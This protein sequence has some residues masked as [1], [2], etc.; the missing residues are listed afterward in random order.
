MALSFVSPSGEVSIQDDLWYVA[1]SSN[2]GQTDFKYVFDVFYK[3]QQLIRTKVFPEPITGK[4]Y[5][6]ATQ[7]VRNEITYD[8]FKP[9]Q[10]DNICISQPSTSGQIGLTYQV[11]VGEDY[12][13]LTT[14][15]LASGST[16][17]YNYL[18]PLFNRR[19]LK[20]D[21]WNNRFLSNRP[22]TTLRHNITDRILIGVKSLVNGRYF[23]VRAYGNSNNFIWQESYLYYQI[24]TGNPF[25]QLDVG[26]TNINNVLF[27]YQITN[28][29]KYW[30]VGFQ[31]TIT[32]FVRVY[33]EC[34]GKYKPVLLHFIN[35]FGM[36]DTARFNLVSKLSMDL[37]RKTYAKRDY[38]F[39]GNSVDY[40]DANNVYK[41]SSINY[42][43][44]IDWKYHLTMNYPTDAEYQ[45]LSE[46]IYSPQI[47]AEIDGAFYP[48]SIINTN[49]E[50]SKNINNGLRALEIDIAMNQTRYGYRR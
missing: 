40:Y 28:D 48:V 37:E 3:G 9:L 34:D 47:Y 5:F 13:G 17:A 24:P 1:S 50:Y 23:N 31:D 19:K 30:E 26:G 25:L 45:W 18:P 29:V 4:G 35:A 16:T 44:K 22:L 6:N 38:S 7:V 11:S 20:L 15:N 46:L 43:S 49:Y 41:E 21:N 12:A 10:G 36:F 14:L 33:N 27:S 2:S 8:Y 42:G 39:N 32:E